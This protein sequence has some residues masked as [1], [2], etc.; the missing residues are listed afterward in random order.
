MQLEREI[1]D[2][3]RLE[4]LLEKACVSLPDDAKAAAGIDAANLSLRLSGGDL[5]SLSAV[6]PPPPPESAPPPPP[7]PIIGGSMPGSTTCLNS[8][9]FACL[10]ILALQNLR[11]HLVL[12]E[13]ALQLKRKF[14]RLRIQ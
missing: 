8:L 13:L 9:V 4:S 3:A 6:P 7:P 2:R 14:Q 12:L 11:H 10:Q 5:S 1:Q